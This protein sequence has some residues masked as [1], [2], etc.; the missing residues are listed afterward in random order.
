[1]ARD[2]IKLPN[3]KWG[4]LILLILEALVAVWALAG[5]FYSIRAGRTRTMIYG[6]ITMFAIFYILGRSLRTFVGLLKQER[7]E[8]E[9]NG[10]EKK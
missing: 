3:N 7:A 2:L 5:V 4:F 1:M 6:L 10:E 8:K 9:G